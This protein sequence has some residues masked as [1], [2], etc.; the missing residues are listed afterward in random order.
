MAHRSVEV[1]VWPVPL[2]ETKRNVLVIRMLASNA[3][4]P[5]WTLALARDRR[6]ARCL[7]FEPI[8]CD[9]MTLALVKPTSV[10]VRAG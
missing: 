7:T 3:G 6:R 9:D 2:V 5:N 10:L 1:I 8:I 4:G